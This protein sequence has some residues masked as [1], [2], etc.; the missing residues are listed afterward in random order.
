MGK[1]MKNAPVYFTLGQ[2]Q[3][4]PLLDLG[5][6]LPSIQESMRKSGYP[7][8]K[9][10]IQVAF[11]LPSTAHHDANQAPQPTLQKIERFMF[12]NRDNNSGFIMLPNALSFQTSAYDTFDTF[13]TE[14][15]R[16]L[17]ILGTAIGGISFVERLGLRYLDAV[18]PAEG[19]TLKQY[20]APELL[21]LPSRVQDA[22]FAYA[23]SESVL[24]AEGVGQVVSRTIIQSGPLGLPP[25]LLPESLPIAERFRGVN[26]EHAVIDT[27]GS[28]TDRRSFDIAEISQ[29]MGALHDLII[30]TFQAT[31]TDYARTTWDK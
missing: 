14:L 7:D 5:S 8:F 17:E 22:V 30:K 2:V 4:N 26:G 13:S 29:R 16:G 15:S 24:I 11:N 18:V 21:G 28:H 27:D 6:F 10:G 3:H 19:E 9:R 25:D 1:K 20:V 23:F 31:V 12:S